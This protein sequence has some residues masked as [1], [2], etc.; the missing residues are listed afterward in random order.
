MKIDIGITD[1]DRSAIAQGLSHLLADT[2]TLYL[3]PK[4]PK[5]QETEITDNISI[6]NNIEGYI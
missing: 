5:P 4:T 1:Q 6:R 3:S 2:Y